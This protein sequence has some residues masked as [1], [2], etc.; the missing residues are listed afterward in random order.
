MKEKVAVACA[1]AALSAQLPTLNAQSPVALG[2]RGRVNAN[3]SLAASGTSVAAVWSSANEQDD[4]D[5]EFALSRDGGATFGP[6]VRVN[7]TPGSARTN[8]EQPPRVAL[9]PRASGPGFA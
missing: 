6:A 4:E 2:A 7:S 9:I 5:I 1:I 3:V 8:G